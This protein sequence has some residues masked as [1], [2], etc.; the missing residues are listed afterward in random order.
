MLEADEEGDNASLINELDYLNEVNIFASQGTKIDDLIV[1]GKMTIINF[2]GTPP[3]IQELIVNRIATAAFELRKLGK[4]P[5]MMMVVEE[6]HNYCPQIGPR[7]LVQDIQDHRVE[8]TEVRSRPHD[9]LASGRPR[10]TRTF[11]RSATPR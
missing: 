8:G 5:P 4:I 2:K 9:N 11:C 7:R 6:A 1:K 3:D 10:S